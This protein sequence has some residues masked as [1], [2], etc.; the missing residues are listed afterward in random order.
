MRT[1]E[2]I[3]K[4]R[5]G[6]ELTAEEIEALL[7]GY[8]SGE[9]PDYQMSALLM[10]VFFRGM[11]AQE[12]TA[13]TMAM[14]R[15]GET[16][17]LRAIRG[18]KVDKHSTGGV[19]DK[20]SLVL[21]PLV[22]AAGVP[23]AKLSGRGLGH[24]GGTLDKLESIPGF[25]TELSAEAFVSQ[26]NRIGC[27]IAGQ[28]ADLVPA[29]KKLYALRDV[30]ATVDSIPLIAASVMSKKITAGSDAIVLDVK[31][32]SGAFMKTL[33]GSRNLA[34]TMVAIGNA[35]GRRTVAVI[36]D[37][38]QPLGMT[39]GNALEVREAIETLR[40]GGPDDLRELCVTLGAQM[41]VLAGI[42]VSEED[43]KA[44]LE[45]LLSDGEARAKFR[46]MVRAQ[47]GDP[48]CVD[49]PERLPKA[50]VIEP[51][52]APSSGV[53]VA[54]DAERIGLA[55]MAL[56]AGRAKKDDVIDPAVGIVLRKKVRD[57]VSEG[58]VLA[59]V[60]AADRRR[61]GEAVARVQAAY[62]IGRS[63]PPAG[64]LIHEIVT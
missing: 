33:D 31:T 62:A 51:A 8:L 47:K 41:L 7:K 23:V 60:H 35:A 16:L 40:D 39:V 30:T 20:T 4:K 36:S 29:D 55:A 26:V 15:S 48:A 56:G 22:A 24:T 45:R 58:E 6:G 5:D 44:R 49:D 63:A 37:M 2:L 9:I 34:K 17:D 46:E 10:A 27:A 43:A 1:Y 64:T 21:I 13:L 42:A 19:G 50:S 3:Q 18:T 52:P 25:T 32:G 38:A 61:A 53:V 12:T 59:A 57:A 11:T 14:V 28:A 54:I